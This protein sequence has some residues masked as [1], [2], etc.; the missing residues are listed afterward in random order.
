MAMIDIIILVLVL[1]GVITGYRMG[2]IKQ[3]AVLTGLVLGLI[4]A[5]ALYGVVGDRLTGIV[6]DNPSLAHLC[7]FVLIW[8]VV[9]LVFSLVASVITKALEIISLGWLNRLLGAALGAVKWVLFI[10]VFICVLDFID[11]D[12]KIVS[13]DLR[14]ESILYKP[15][16]AV[17]GMF[18]PAVQDLAN[19]ILEK[20][21][22][23][24]QQEEIHQNQKNNGVETREI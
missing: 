11:A 7:A 14:E 9:P 22:Q 2:F 4:V 15:I 1:V 16:G 21:N 5:K 24:Q 12:G 10:S 17:A 20:H 23:K 13:Q 6:S 3:L 18:M 19:D 8:L